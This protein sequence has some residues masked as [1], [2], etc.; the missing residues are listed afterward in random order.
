MQLAPTLTP[1]P[2]HGAVH[3]TLAGTPGYMPPEIMG[4]FFNVSNAPNYDGTKADI[5]SAG[6]GPG[7]GVVA[8][9]GP[10]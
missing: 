8:T 5:Y 4:G 6:G 7:L 2:A 9:M 3:Q 10:L 1:L